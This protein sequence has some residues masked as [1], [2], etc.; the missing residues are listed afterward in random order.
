MKIDHHAYREEEDDQRIRA[1]IGDCY[2]VT[3]HPFHSLDP[4]NWERFIVSSKLGADRNRI[5][6]WQMTDHPQYKLVGL[7]VYQRQ[8]DEFSCL[9]HPEILGIDDLIYE[10]VEKGHKGAIATQ[11]D[12]VSLKCS[13]CEGNDRQKKI[14]VR[15]GYT[16]GPIG[17][18]FRRRPLT[19]IV[20]KPLLPSGYALHGVPQ[21]SAELLLERALIEGSLFNHEITVDFL[22]GLQRTPA[23][24]PELDL[25]ITTPTGNIAAFCTLWFDNTTRAG[26]VE[27]MGTTAGHRQQGLAKAL[28]LEGF[29][30]LQK[31]GAE[32]LYLGH[33]AGNKA[34]N[35]LYESVGLTLFD[36]EYLWQKIF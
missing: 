29:Q 20:A 18:V 2:K 6:L 11:N 30:R 22:E 23:Y 32:I 25:A 26:F 17:T 35:Q 1:F 28:L 27:P 31:M 13:V 5:H 33:S 34:A 4:P 14:L 36:R 9:V 21:L 24:R 8:R 16:R 19:G 7:V 12:K 15:R 10:W 3:H